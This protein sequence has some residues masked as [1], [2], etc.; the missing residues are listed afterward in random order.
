MNFRYQPVFI[1]EDGGRQY[2]ACEVHFDDKGQ[3]EAWSEIVEPVGDTMQ[4]F[5][6]CLSAMLADVKK[7]KPVGFSEL[8]VGFQFERLTD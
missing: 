2:G 7:W 3:L 5:L 4:G 6:E 8:E 1:E